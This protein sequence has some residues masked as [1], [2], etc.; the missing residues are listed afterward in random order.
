MF[1]RKTHNQ[2]TRYTF[3]L[4]GNCAWKITGFGFANRRQPTRH[5]VD[6]AIS[7]RRFLLISWVDLWIFKAFVHV[8]GEWIL[9]KSGFRI[10]RMPCI[11]KF[12]LLS[13][14]QKLFMWLHRADRNK[15]NEFK[16]NLR[17]I[18]S[19]FKNLFKR[20]EEKNIWWKRKKV[21]QL[22]LIKVSSA[23][24]SICQC[25]EARKGWSRKEAEKMYI[26]KNIDFDEWNLSSE[27]KGKQQKLEKN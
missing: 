15:R 13:H 18:S 12:I 6:K 14:L 22:K 20:F 5:R 8:F 4:P 26:I 24:T 7:K 16:Q 27:K 11:F 17:K 25:M 3:E 21:N 2:K 10:Q 9:T 19:Y 23:T 1:E